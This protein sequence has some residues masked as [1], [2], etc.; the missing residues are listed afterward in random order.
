MPMTH[1]SVAVTVG[2]G[3]STAR[4]GA[5][6]KLD[7]KYHDEPAASEV[8]TRCNHRGTGGLEGRPLVT[9]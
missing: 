2:Q 6:R 9:S 3:D 8:M 7:P 1:H 4:I 5:N